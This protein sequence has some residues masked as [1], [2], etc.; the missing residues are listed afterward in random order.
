VSETGGTVKF[1]VAGA[2]SASVTLTGGQAQVIGG[3]T[4]PLTIVT[5]SGFSTGLTLTSGA[6]SVQTNG[7]DNVHAGSGADSVWIKG[8]AST[9]TGG[10]GTLSVYNGD[11]SASDT[12]TIIGGRGAISLTQNCGTLNFIGGTGSATIDG[13]SGQLFITGGSGSLSVMNGN[14]GEQIIAGTGTLTAALSSNG[15]TVEFGAGTANIQ[16]AGFGLGDIFNFVAGHGGGTDTITGFRLGVDT[17][18]FSGVTIKS[19]TVVGTQTR[20][21]LSDNTHVVLNG[22]SDTQGVFAHH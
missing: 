4:S 16:E 12:Q 21:V 14:L 5:N 17:L 18:N 20:L 6:V 22:F 13:G 15:G 10:T 2:A 8:G 11:T 1:G 19:E 3:T 7:N 9:I